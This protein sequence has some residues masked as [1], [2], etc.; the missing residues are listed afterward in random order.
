MDTFMDK[1]SEKLTAQEMI[2]A[3]AAAETEEMN[4]LKE[5]VQE[6]TQ[7][8]DRMKTI[9]ADIEKSCAEMAAPDLRDLKEELLQ[10]WQ[11]TADALNQRVAE[12]ISKGIADGL[13]QHT[14][15]EPVPDRTE[16]IRRDLAD[17]KEQL[18]DMP[19]PQPQQPVAVEIDQ[20]EILENIKLLQQDQLDSLRSVIKAQMS[21]IKDGQA[22]N[23]RDLV[24][25]NN[26][27]LMTQFG[28][29]KTN[30]ETQLGGANEFVHKECVKVYRNVQAVIGEENIKQSE[31][32]DYILKPMSARV[33]T[34][35]KISIAALICSVAGVALQVVNLLH[36][37]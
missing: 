19:A 13:Q 32:L 8:L 17:I 29:L 37:F 30:V 16:E 11:E 9:S 3:N 22:E 31:N 12:E 6:Y 21:G 27:E 36:L 34:L 24:E 23:L 7:C 18:A 20:T 28:E 26:T 25:S 15:S 1:L 35:M 2:Q 5:Q 33:G 10:M 4:R 14:A